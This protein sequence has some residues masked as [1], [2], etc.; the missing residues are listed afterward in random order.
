[1]CLKY[2]KNNNNN[3]NNNKEAAGGCVELESIRF[4]GGAPI[5]PNTMLLV[6]I[7]KK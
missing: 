4:E 3:S 2:N 1:M 6:E 5:S 7:R